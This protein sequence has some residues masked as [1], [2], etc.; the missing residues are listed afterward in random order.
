MAGIAFLVR[1]GYIYEAKINLTM[2]YTCKDAVEMLAD[3]ATVVVATIAVYYAWKTYRVARDA[4]DEWKIQKDLDFYIRFSKVLAKAK[5]YLIYLRSPLSVTSE[6]SDKYLDGF[7]KGN[8]LDRDALRPYYQELLIAS[9]RDRNVD[10]RREI[11]SI[12][13]ESIMYINDDH[14]IKLFLKFII[15]T[16][17]MVVR[18]SRTYSLN[19]QH[20]KEGGLHSS[21]IERYIAENVEIINLINSCENDKISQDLEILYNN[22]I[23]DL[24]SIKEKTTH[25]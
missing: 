16:E 2:Y 8:V 19:S 14:P 23:S 12:Y 17:E 6:I 18:K 1:L 22:C 20:I 3:V 5:D 10:T 21:Q 24:K 4:K 13:Y 9:K 7:M 11:M 15:D 25:V